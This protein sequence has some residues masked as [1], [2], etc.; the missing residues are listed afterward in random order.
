MCTFKINP[1][2]HTKFQ[3][4]NLKPLQKS[5]YFSWTHIVHYLLNLSLF[6]MAG[7][8]KI[9]KFNLVILKQC[10]GTAKKIK[11]KTMQ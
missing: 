8:K 9:Q 5:T 4:Q 2:Y 3:L 7:K 6:L 1:L 10:K 11:T